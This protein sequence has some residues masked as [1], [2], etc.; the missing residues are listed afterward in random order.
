MSAESSL[1]AGAIPVS[2]RNDLGYS[3]DGNTKKATPHAVPEDTT[4]EGTSRECAICLETT[5]SRQTK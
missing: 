1:T 4:A 2:Q 5:D 3:H